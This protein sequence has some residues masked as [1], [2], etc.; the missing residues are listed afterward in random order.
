MDLV[1]LQNPDLKIKFMM[2]KDYRRFLQDFNHYKN[3][4]YYHEIM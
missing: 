1:V 3:I 2:E 4:P